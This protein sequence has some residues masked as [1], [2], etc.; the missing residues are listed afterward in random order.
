MLAKQAKLIPQL[1]E[2]QNCLL[3]IEKI[4]EVAEE[5]GTWGGYH[6]LFGEC[7]KSGQ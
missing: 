3:L 1:T 7:R 6:S 4:V 5:G 2:K